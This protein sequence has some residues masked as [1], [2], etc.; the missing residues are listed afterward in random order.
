MTNNIFKAL[1][2]ITLL[3]TLVTT[4]SPGTLS[5]LDSYSMIITSLLVLSIGWFLTLGVY[6]NEENGKDEIV[7]RRM[8]L[9][10]T[11]SLPLLAMIFSP[12]FLYPYIVG[13]AFVFRFLAIVGFSSFVYLALTNTE[14]KP[15]VSPYVF[16]FGVFTLAMLVSVLFSMDSVRSFWSNYERME[17]YIEL[18][19][20]FAV[21]VAITS[22]RL[23]EIEWKRV[24][25]VHVYVSTFV[26]GMGV[27][28]KLVQVIGLNVGNLPIIGLCISQGSACR[29]DSTLGN[30]IYLG[31][32]AALT[33]WLIV[34][35]YYSRKIGGYLLPALAFLNLLAVYFS[36]TRGVWL[37]MVLGF[38]VA[39]IT[40][41]YEKKNYKAVVGTVLAGILVLGLLFGGV[42]YAK[43]N[44]IGQ[45]V[46]LVQRLSSVN[47]LF[48]RWTI[49]KMAIH[50]WTEKPLFGWGQENF[51][52][53]F[54]K[55]YD[56]AMYGQ[57]TY[58]DH[59][60]NTYIGWLVFG[61]ILGFLA[62]L[63]MLYTIFFGVTKEYFKEREKDPLVVPIVFAALTTY[64][65]HIFF[66][67][68]NLTSTVLITFMAIYFSRNVSYGSV[69]V[70]TI[71]S[72]NKRTLYIAL[73]LVSVFIIYK[74]I[75]LPSYA[76]LSV[77]NSMT[78]Q[79]RF[80]AG[81]NPAEIIN[82]TKEGYEQ[83][84]ALNTFGN[85]EIR[86]FFL[87]KS[88]EYIGL[89]PQVKDENT[90]Q[91]ILAFA[92]SAYSQ[93]QIQTANA[94]Y[95]HRAKFM[96]GLYLL[97]I[98]NYDEAIKVLT[99]ANALAPNKQI[100]II[101]LAKAYLL[102]GDVD[103]ASKLYER[104][105]AITPTNIA[106]HAQ[107]VAEFEQVKLLLASSTVQAQLKDLRK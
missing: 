70:P 83:A 50:S 44:N 36:G 63:L 12:S 73:T 92:Q 1:L 69:K 19:S 66:V 100:S 101:Y 9:A 93:F 8:L 7:A 35:V 41:L 56:P 74:T 67:F 90:K 97:N 85:Y 81:T 52:H 107:L 17:G 6:K 13:K 53:A 62:F 80:P 34:Y 11:F 77:I 27:L 59:P 79:Q 31:I 91:A 48:A 2:P 3:V 75:Y 29:V 37:G 58:F 95:D 45:N 89:L 60:H 88:L 46:E 32:Y 4:F 86:E 105:I 47:T 21:I 14:Y 76:N 5:S 106:G 98:K 87:Q 24:F 94:P 78:M 64:L 38:G 26:S 16:G 15:R 72:N 102:K 104:A 23:K 10:V 42:M 28:Q 84:I 71:S 39:V 96:Q 43:A 40:W 82:K 22:A 103:A 55:D 57:E 25:M 30:S 33:F 49:W 68:D 51:I 20:V 18:F 65:V 54:N 61:G 99:E